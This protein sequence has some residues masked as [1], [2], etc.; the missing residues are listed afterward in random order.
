[1]WATFYTDGPEIFL[2]RMQ[3]KFDFLL[4]ENNRTMKK[5]ALIGS[6]EGKESVQVILLTC[7]PFT[8]V[9]L[10]ASS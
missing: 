1:M 9:F 6:K 7:P 10:V 3:K 4:Q 8:G 2:R 5:R